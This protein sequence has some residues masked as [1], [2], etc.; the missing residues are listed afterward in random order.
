MNKDARFIAL[1][2]LEQFEINKGQL[3]LIR[4]TI[5]SRFSPTNISK[6]R[7]N[8]LINE[9]VR[10]KGKL[11]LMIEFVSGKPIKRLNMSLLSILRISFYEIIKDSK[12]PNYAT[13]DCS[14]ELTRN[15]LN[16]KA[17]GFTNA[18]LRKLIRIM[19]SDKKWYYPLKKKIGWNSIP[20]WLQKKW[21]N[22]FK[23]NE[24]LKL[25][26]IIN[27]PS[28]IF[29]RLDNQNYLIGDIIKI[30]DNEGIKSEIFSK[31]FLKIK[32][33]PG[34][35]LRT[36]LFQTGEISI[37]NPASAAVVECLGAQ[38][39]DIVLDVCAAPGTKTLQ[40]ANLVGQ[41]GYVW[42]SDL[43]LERV[44]R[45]RKD[46]NRHR[47]KNIHWSI[48]DAR[49]DTYPRV[50]RILIDAPCTGTGIIGKKPEIRWVRKPTDI[51]KLSSLQ[52]DIINHCSQFLKSGG[53][54][55]YSTCSI[56]PEENWDI[57][58]KFIKINDDFV[59]DRLPT[60]IPKSWIDDKGVLK[61]LPHIHLV[62][63][64]FAA[65]LKKL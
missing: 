43:V 29:I 36:K 34:K 9:V 8:V 50:N 22:Q 38:L 47:K 31:T 56:E 64:I 44:K 40:L 65:R 60:S 49:K 55:V 39:D 6:S 19:D 59:L 37:Q 48:K 35:I 63:G 27:K 53:T 30:L 58:E 41:K 11:D 62:D 20:E 1:K 57:I 24:F 17:A 45:G 32:S 61:T 12:T 46:M 52:F 7:A 13:V 15:I 26:K 18:I 4:N 33:G 28:E 21:K 10:L 23:K 2:I 25:V 5:F 54:M 51:Q 16:Q 3:N 42:A 14:V